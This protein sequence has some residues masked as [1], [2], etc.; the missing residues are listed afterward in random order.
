VHGSTR[1][2]LANVETPIMPTP[3]DCES[4]EAMRATG[5]LGR[6]PLN[7]WPHERPQMARETEYLGAM[8]A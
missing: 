6:D 8:G 5:T 3:A 4:D 2:V 7:S 1:R